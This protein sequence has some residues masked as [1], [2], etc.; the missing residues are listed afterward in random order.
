[1]ASPRAAV[2]CI[3]RHQG[4]VLLQRIVDPK[5][6]EV[7]W[8]VPGGGL[9]WRETA[10]QALRR[11]V[12]EELGVD[13][14]SFS[15]RA[16]VEG[17]IHWDGK[18]EHEIVFVFDAIPVSWDELNSKLGDAR[19]AD[20]KPLDLRWESPGDLVAAGERF[21]PEATVPHLLGHRTSQHIRAVALCAF[22]RGDQV[23]VFE[24]WDAVKQRR[25]RRFPGGG[26][27]Y[28]ETAEAAVRREMR[29]ELDTE[30]TGL[31]LLGVLENLFEF[32]GQPGHENVFVFG[33]E[34]V[35]PEKY[36]SLETFR[37]ADDGGWVDVAWVPISDLG[38]P[39]APLVPEAVLG[40][41]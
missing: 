24:G 35:E 14:A 26:I 16:V 27:E 41:L 34:F 32:E 6:A 12:R 20:G 17:F 13:L 11:E 9:E 37:M 10:E 4:K 3:F 15:Q 23:L 40:L 29:E 8:R 25:F 7:C 21:Y 33:A 2:H 30:L 39:L 36:E 5:T 38:D 28:G 19:E 18:D 22:R 31:R 1:M